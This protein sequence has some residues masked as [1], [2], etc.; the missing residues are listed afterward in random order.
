MEIAFKKFDKDNSG[1]ISH[2][3]IRSVL[4]AQE[5]KLPHSVIDYLIMQVD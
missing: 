2:E 4:V 1:L 5:N 3:E